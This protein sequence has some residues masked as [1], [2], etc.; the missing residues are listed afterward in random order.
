MIHGLAWIWYTDMAIAG[1]SVPS[2]LHKYCVLCCNCPSVDSSLPES[3]HRFFVP[4][5]NRLLGSL[6]TH[7][8]SLPYYHK[9]LPF[10]EIPTLVVAVAM[11]NRSGAPTA[12]PAVA[13]Q[14]TKTNTARKT[15]K[16]KSKRLSRPKSNNTRTANRIQKPASGRNARGYVWV[17]E[18][19][20]T[21][22]LAPPAPILYLQRPHLPAV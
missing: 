2:G 9:H 5:K 7:I 14:A 21:I 3:L 1:D 6:P 18:T 19:P 8:I 15:N 4:P 17:D 22:P 13:S 20:G 16:A 10:T 12:T 11:N